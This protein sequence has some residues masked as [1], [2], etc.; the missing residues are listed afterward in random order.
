MH[1]T[2]VPA[3]I[4]IFWSGL[5][6]ALVFERCRSLLPAIIAH[7]TGNMLA[8]ASVLLFYR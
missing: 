8:L 3:F 5:V 1:G 2:S 6:W 4:G 7:S